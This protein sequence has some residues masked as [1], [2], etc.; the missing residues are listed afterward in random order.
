[1]SEEELETRICNAVLEMREY[2][3]YDYFVINDRL[4]DA[5]EDIRSIIRV[6]IMKHERM[7]I[8]VDAILEEHK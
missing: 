8:R 4:E 7:D 2:K 6:E 1:E 3:N 5:I